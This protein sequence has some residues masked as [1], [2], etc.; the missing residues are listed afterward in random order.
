[1]KFSYVEY[2]RR[3]NKKC[4]FCGVPFVKYEGTY[5]NGEHVYMC[6]K[7]VAIHINELKED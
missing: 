1:M 4:F 6:N 3:E 7:C 5:I 2:A